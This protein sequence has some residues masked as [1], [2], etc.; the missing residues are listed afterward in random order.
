[1]ARGWYGLLRANA[2][3]GD[4]ARIL[5]RILVDPANYVVPR[6]RVLMPWADV[7]AAGYTYFG[8]DTS[9]ENYRIELITDLRA[10]V[11]SNRTYIAIDPT[12]AALFDVANQLRRLTGQMNRVIRYLEGNFDRSD[13]T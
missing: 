8:A 1:M 6:G 11:A 12:L 10:A 13:P 2:P 9:K 5:G 4:L 7:E 3:E